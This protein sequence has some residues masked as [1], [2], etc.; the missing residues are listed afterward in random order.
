MNPTGKKTY[1]RDASE[2][3][4]LAEKLRDHKIKSGL[5]Y[6][7]WLKQLGMESQI[8]QINQI[9]TGKRGMMFFTGIRMANKCKIDLS[10]LQSFKT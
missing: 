10:E 7:K 8:P 1:G 4:W 2:T 6:R 5:S 3:K 9:L